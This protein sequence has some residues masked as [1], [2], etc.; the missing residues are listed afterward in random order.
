[1]FVCVCVCLCVFVC[2]WNS[3]EAVSPGEERC[4]RVFLF[5]VVCVYV[6]VCVCESVCVSLCVYVFCLARWYQYQQYS[7]ARADINTEDMRDFRDSELVLCVFAKTIGACVLICLFLCL[8][9]F[10]FA[11]L[12]ICMCACSLLC[13]FASLSL[14]ISAH[15]CVFSPPFLFLCGLLPL[16]LSPIRPDYTKSYRGKWTVSGR[17]PRQRF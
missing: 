8:L 6:C 15:L 17:P 14:Q 1:V 3:H 11:C 10:L 9:V 2:V 16:L 4:V 13:L 7:D 12:P 5:L